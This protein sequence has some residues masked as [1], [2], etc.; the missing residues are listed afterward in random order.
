MEKGHKIDV[1]ISNLGH[2][3]DFN[4]SKERFIDIYIRP[5]VNYLQD[6]LDRQGMIPDA[7]TSSHV[8]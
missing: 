6:N 4:L 3:D 5:I 8:I 7:S 1:T 2:F